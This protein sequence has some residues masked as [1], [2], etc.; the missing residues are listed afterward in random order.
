MLE[1]IKELFIIEETIDLNNG[2]VK[3]YVPKVN[4]K[5]TLRQLRNSPEFEF[6]MLLSIIAMEAPDY[7]ELAY[8]LYSTTL[9][10]NIVIATKL[11]LQSLSIETVSDIYKS[12]DWDEREIFDLF[13]VN[14]LMH[15]NLKRLLLPKDWKGHP[16]R[17]DYVMDDER[18]AWNQ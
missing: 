14:F 7:F 13:G 18:L 16:L 4:L 11:S 12:A 5:D 8:N 6:D 3:Y 17:K 2:I 9:N 1:Q 10:L 15:P